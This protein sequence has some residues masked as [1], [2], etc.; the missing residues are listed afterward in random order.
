MQRLSVL[1]F[2]S[3]GPAAGGLMGKVKQQSALASWSW[4]DRFA[5]YVWDL[6]RTIYSVWP[7]LTSFVG[8]IRK[9]SVCQ[10]GVLQR[11]G[12]L[13][14]SDGVSWFSMQFLCSLRG[15]CALNLRCKTGR[16][17]VRDIG[18]LVK[19]EFGQ[20]GT[21]QFGTDQTT[22]VRYCQTHLSFHW[23]IYFIEVLRSKCAVR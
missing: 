19:S 2:S 7:S 1:I 11:K 6:G 23:N 15:T 3:Q 10:K 8:P 22:P 4:T 5:R 21:G 18:R 16:E 20:F 12:H 14:T 9:M 17:G 13:W